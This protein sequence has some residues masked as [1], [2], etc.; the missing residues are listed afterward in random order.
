MKDKTTKVYL[1]CILEVAKSKYKERR[2]RK[3]E[4]KEYLT[5]F[6]KVLKTFTKW[7]G[8]RSTDDKYPNHWKSVY[9]EFNKW[10]KDGIFNIAF[11]TF[12]KNNYFKLNKI[13]NNRR[14][15]MFIDATKI[16]NLRGKE[17][18][19]MNNEY[20][21]KNIT[22]L[23]VICD[24]NKLPIAFSNIGPNKVF[25]NG[26]KTACHEITGVQSALDTIPFEIPSYVNIDIIGDK[27]YLT[28]EIFHIK[29][30][31]VSII[32]PKR[33]NQ[34]VKNTNK[35]RKLLNK[36]SKIEHVFATLKS[37]HRVYVRCETKLKQYCS[38]VYLSMLEMYFNFI[39]R[40]NILNNLHL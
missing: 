24:D 1:K 40:N 38:F 23:T 30:R 32:A 27:G 12:V 14:I 34:K 18:L 5:A 9:N 2:K 6:I 29:N 20:R 17:G 22:P 39:E 31:I 16:N 35:E 21:K 33:K 3:Y 36:R 37:N 4:L 7:E 11:D 10:T 25:N 13:R 8:L 19:T 28:R 15:T 26:R